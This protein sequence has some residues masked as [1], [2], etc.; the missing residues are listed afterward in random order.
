MV[1]IGGTQE[2]IHPEVQVALGRNDK[3]RR[4]EPLVLVAPRPVQMHLPL[5]FV[6]NGTEAGG[7]RAL[8]SGG[9]M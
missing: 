4:D 3:L 6:R 1:A 5:A 8:P 2:A 7:L 9:V